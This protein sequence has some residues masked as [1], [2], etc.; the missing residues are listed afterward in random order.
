MRI[1]NLCCLCFASVCLFLG[2]C[3]HKS[4]EY[5]KSA[6][7]KKVSKIDA[8][9]HYNTKDIRYLEYAASLNFRLISP[10]VD[11]GVSIDDQLEIARTVKQRFPDK[12]TFLG[13][14]SVDSFNNAGFADRTIARIDKCMK[15][16][17]SG[18][19]IWKNIGMVL[20][21]TSG[22]F[23]MERGRVGQTF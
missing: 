18:I 21:D 22:R 7:F 12:F 1:S 19:K 2:G 11:A 23:V 13:T 20:K 3:S 4:A 9:F 14:F 6:D 8:H 15:M 17:A 16:G 10:N 5:Y